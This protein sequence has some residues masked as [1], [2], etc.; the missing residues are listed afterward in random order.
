MAEKEAEA[1]GGAA[2]VAINPS[3]YD[4]ERR[5][6]DQTIELRDQC[7]MLQ[8][9]KV[10]LQPA[11]DHLRPA[12]NRMHPACNRM[13]PACKRASSPQPY[14]LPPTSQAG[15]MPL[16]YL[17]LVQ[18]LVDSLTALTAP[19]LYPK[20]RVGASPSPSP[21]PNPNPSP[22]PSPN[23]IQDWYPLGGSH[24]SAH[25]LLSRPPSRVRRRP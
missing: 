9:D 19:A 25:R 18:L 16:A 2:D 6:D 21:S 3:S 13:R 10:G 20:V 4:F 7:H 8:T 15:R 17:H 22:N 11:C 1:R 24:R 12:C 23:P 14:Y 5:F